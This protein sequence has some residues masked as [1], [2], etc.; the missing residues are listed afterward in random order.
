MTYTPMMPATGES[1]VVQ[2]VVIRDPA[3]PV[4]EAA[5]ML[6]S[7][8]CGLLIGKSIHTEASPNGYPVVGTL[9]GMF[10]GCRGL[11]VLAGY[12]LWKNK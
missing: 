12:S 2:P 7:G 1:V 4:A 11:A 3:F 6:V 8:F 5:G 9:L 10:T